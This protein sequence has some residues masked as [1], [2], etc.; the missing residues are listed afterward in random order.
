VDDAT[1]CSEKQSYFVAR[2]FV[3]A[4]YNMTQNGHFVP[5]S[6]AH[7]LLPLNAQYAT[8]EYLNFPCRPPTTSDW[9]NNCRITLNLD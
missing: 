3:L 1:L 2:S 6:I 9:M 5:E 7:K 8:V 4:V